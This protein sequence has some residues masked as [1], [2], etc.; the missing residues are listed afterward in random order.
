MNS[1]TS[2][3]TPQAV[4][5]ILDEASGLDGVIVLHSTRLG[6]AAGGCRLWHYNDVASAAHDAMRLAEGMAYKNALAD[7]PLGG[8]KAVLRLPEGRFDR[9]R[10]FAA[11]GRA[12]EN[13]GTKRGH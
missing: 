2:P 4:H 10:L 5:R 11:F 6:P 12:V 13:T 1:A 3:S 8:G 9:Q 7:L